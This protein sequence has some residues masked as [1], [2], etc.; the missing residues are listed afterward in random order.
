MGVMM[1]YEEAVKQVF[2]RGNNQYELVLPYTGATKLHIRHIACGIDFYKPLTKLKENSC[3]ECRRKSQIKS[4]DWFI[5]QCKL[6]GRTDYTV[7]GK[8]K[9][10]KTKVLIKHDICGYEWNVTPD[11]FLRRASGCPKCNKNARVKNTQE[12]NAKVSALYRDEYQFIGKYINARTKQT[13]IHA[14]CNK[15]WDVEPDSILQ[16]NSHCPFCK[17]SIG[18]HDTRISLESLGIPYVAQKRFI[19]CKDNKQLPFDFYLP[20]HKALIEYDGIQHYAPV[21]MF[22]GNSAYQSQ[23]KRDAIKTAYTNKHDMILIRIP[24]TLPHEDIKNFILAKLNIKK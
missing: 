3:N 23:V 9:S 17:E 10:A 22:G 15:S 12:L 6:K 2:I 21:G 24:Y 1:S 16:G 7:I 19:D 5:Q 13:C 14:T 11:N 8:Y 20:K 18:E 4:H